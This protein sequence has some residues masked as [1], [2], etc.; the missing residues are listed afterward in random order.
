MGLITIIG[1]GW[2]PGEWNGN[3]FQYSCL[4]NPMDGPWGHKRVGHDLATEQQ[5]QLVDLK[6]D[7]KDLQQRNIN[8]LHIDTVI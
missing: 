7:G 8:T 3:L 5:Q 1:W 4:G 2:P 6:W